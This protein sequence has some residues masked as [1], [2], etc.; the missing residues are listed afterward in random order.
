MP[1]GYKIDEARQVVLSCGWADVAGEHVLWH[2][3]TLA[4]D[5]R[6]TPDLRQIAD[7]RRITDFDVSAAMMERLAE[8]SPFGCGARRAFVVSTPVVY[9]LARMFANLRVRRG[10]EFLVSGDI[11]EALD[12]LGLADARA[13]LLASLASMPDMVPEWSARV[14]AARSN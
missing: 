6:F 8:L 14:S 4:A 7:L 11:D 3:R 2:L 10:D 13:E 1:G 5:D 9:G 12:W